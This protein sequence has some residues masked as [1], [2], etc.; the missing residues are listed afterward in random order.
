MD[1]QMIIEKIRRGDAA[2]ITQLYES[3]RPIVKKLVAK[4]NL[5]KYDE[6]DV[7]DETII[8]FYIFCKKEDAVLT[9]KPT[10]YMY[11][12]CDNICISRW[13]KF[14]KNAA[15][16]DT[17][18][19]LIDL[20]V[21]KADLGVNL[22]LNDLSEAAIALKSHNCYIKLPPRCREILLLKYKLGKTHQEIAAL[23]GIEEG[24]SRRKTSSCTTQFSNCLYINLLEDT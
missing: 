22:D 6:E 5:P 23:L 17:V 13:R 9:C 3:M 20:S 7:L 1:Y 4:R 10:T 12:A 19:E 11:M 24:Y 2:T 14:Y 18:D 15:D 21:G 8:A 16:A